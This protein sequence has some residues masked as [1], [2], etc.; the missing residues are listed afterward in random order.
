[1]EKYEKVKF[2]TFTTSPKPAQF[3]PLAPRYS[4]FQLTAEHLARL[5]RE[6]I[7]T[8]AAANH[9]YITRRL[10]FWLQRRRE[11]KWAPKWRLPHIRVVV[12][13]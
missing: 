9:I 10:F 6:L 1:M 7:P 3:L 13:A 8:I 4:C 12:R 2:E 5:R 11:G